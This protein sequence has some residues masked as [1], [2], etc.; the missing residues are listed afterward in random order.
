MRLNCDFDVALQRVRYR[1]TVFGAISCVDESGL[2]DVGD[3]AGGL[4][5]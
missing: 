5:W 2:V 4:E 1:A 3:V